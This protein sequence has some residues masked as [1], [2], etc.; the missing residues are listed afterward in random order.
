MKRCYTVAIRFNL[1]RE[2][3]RNALSWLNRRNEAGYKTNSEAV[4]AALNGHFSRQ[5]RLKNDPYLETREKENAFLE[6]ILDTIRDGLRESGGVGV[7][8]GALRGLQPAPPERQPD[9][10][11][12]R[13][14]METAMDFLDYL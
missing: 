3:D 9:N 4:I 12:K 2:A 6:R 7:L 5:A 14:S 10:A 1:D 11:A 8:L 13:E